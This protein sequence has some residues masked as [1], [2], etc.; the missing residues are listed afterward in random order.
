MTW[1]SVADDLPLPHARILVAGTSGSGK[2]TLARRIAHTLALPYFELDALF[3]APGW[4]ER[5]TFASDVT[6]QIARPRWVTEYQYQ[7]VQPR[8]ADRAQLLVWLDLPRAVVM[9][10]VVRRTVVRRLTRAEILNGN[11][12]PPLHRFFTD[13]DHIVRWSF[14][15]HPRT[16]Q[17]VGDARAQRPDLPVVRLRNAAE[18][19]AWL[20]GPVARAAPARR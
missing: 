14:R 3:H 13:P 2:S 1:L 4:T 8:L 17:R 16:E 15:T 10:R 19:D 7:A 11:V 5:A 18:C 12:E 6:A 9:R 20:S